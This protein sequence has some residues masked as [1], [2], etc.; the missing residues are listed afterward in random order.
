MKKILALIDEC[1]EDPEFSINNLCAKLGMSRSSLYNKLKALTD[2][3]PN[4][5]IRIIRLKKA[6]E[7]LRSRR[8][9]ISEVAA[10]T[11]FPDSSYFSTAFKRQYGM[12]PRKYLSEDPG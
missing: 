11:G 4:D 2:Q 5:F 12:S 9:N 6:A 10:M 8:Y 7:L 3:A 1:M